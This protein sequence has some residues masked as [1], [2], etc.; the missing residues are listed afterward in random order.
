MAN[1]FD[2]ERLRS[3]AASE[4]ITASADK[5]IQRG[6]MRLARRLEKYW[7]DQGYPAARFWAE[8]VDER[9]S[10]VGTYE[11]YRVACNLVNGRPP[12]G[13]PFGEH[14]GARKSWSALNRKTW[15][16]FSLPTN[17]HT[18]FQRASF[19][20]PHENSEGERKRRKRN[21][22]GNEAPPIYRAASAAL[23]GL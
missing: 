6:A 3:G 1:Q 16:P 11:I 19:S 9:F 15:R 8:P 14:L 13:P 4:T 12:G 2:E 22:I 5:L 7:H 10:R 21:R 18:Q 23:S 20:G 17:D